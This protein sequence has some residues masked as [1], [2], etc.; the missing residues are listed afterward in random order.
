M[1][2]LCW[3]NMR[4]TQLPPTAFP[5]SRCTWLHP[6]TLSYETTCSATC[7]NKKTPDIY[8]H[9]EPDIWGAFYQAELQIF[10]LTGSKAISFQRMDSIWKDT[11][12]KNPS[13]V[14]YYGLFMLISCRASG[15]YFK[16]TLSVLKRWSRSFMLPPNYVITRACSEWTC[17][18]RLLEGFKMQLPFCTLTNL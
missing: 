5:R 4:K 6:F 1:R 13:Q 2:G 9:C 8:I 3:L 12:L 17:C 11:L 16:C 7:Y 14:S 18:P 10:A 15:N